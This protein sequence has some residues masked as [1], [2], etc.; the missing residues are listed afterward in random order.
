MESE[1][2][3][4]QPVA[5]DG[6][7]GEEEQ[8]QQEQGQAVGPAPQEEPAEVVEAVEAE[9][10]Q[11]IY[12]FPPESQ[13]V[14][15]QADRLVPP[16]AGP[17]GMPLEEAV[18]R[19]L[20]YPPPP[21]FY[22]NMSEVAQRPPL[23]P[24]WQQ[25]AAPGE[26]ALP[27]PAA[28]PFGYRPGTQTLPPHSTPPQPG[29]AMPPAQKPS[30]KWIWIVVS[31]FSLIVLLSCAL[32]GWA[33]YSIFNTSFQLTNGVITTVNDYYSAI[34]QKNYTAAYSELAPQG[35]I[36]GLTQSAFMQQAQQRDQQYGPV[37]S[38]VYGQPSFGINTSNQPD[39][40]HMTM[41]VSVTRTHLNYNVVLSLQKIGGKWQITDFDRI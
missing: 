10:L 9:A 20:I 14:H 25:P 27:A 6:L 16:A 38:Y 15:A 41:T 2:R 5:E 3:D 8:A 12:E 39:L 32:C 7:R 40:T 26:R 11:P 4:Q 30:R 23:P 18:R 34:E 13:F 36:T 1:S 28:A 37:T 29:T 35:S 21:S 17:A 19:G 33:F 22:Q 31:F 24:A